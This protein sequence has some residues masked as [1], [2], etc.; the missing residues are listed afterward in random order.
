MN[1]YQISRTDESSYD[2]FISAIV[3]ANN[4]Q[5]AKTVRPKYW[6]LGH[7]GYHSEYAF[8]RTKE[9]WE[10]S[11]ND[12]WTNSPDNIVVKLLAENVIPPTPEKD[13][14][15]NTIGFNPCILAYNVGC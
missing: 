6:D 2:A 14:T 13:E 12:S 3:Y 1:I 10:S 11:D 9:D 15:T 8:N 4:E 7:Y 5:E